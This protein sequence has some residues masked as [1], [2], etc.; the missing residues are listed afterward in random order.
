VF[1]QRRSA[2][3]TGR[4]VGTGFQNGRCFGGLAVVLISGWVC[5]PTGFNQVF[6]VNPRNRSDPLHYKDDQFVQTFECALYAPVEIIDSA[7]D[8]GWRPRL[9]FAHIMVAKVA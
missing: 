7:A 8:A 4:R 1:L 9:F 6:Y 3:I 5:H 2:P